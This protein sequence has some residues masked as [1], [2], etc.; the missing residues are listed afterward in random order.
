M[1]KSLAYRWAER[2]IYKFKYNKYLS[3][4]FLVVAIIYL[5]DVILHFNYKS[6]ILVIVFILI[7]AINFEKKG[8]Q[9]IIEEKDKEIIQ[10]KEKND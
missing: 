9:E 7:V 2:D 4:I 5:I 6:L 1:K 8:Y 3:I 10:L